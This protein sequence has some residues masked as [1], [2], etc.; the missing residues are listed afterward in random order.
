MMRDM[1]VEDQ[2]RDNGQRKVLMDEWPGKR[3]SSASKF[4][5]LRIKF[6]SGTVHSGLVARAW[7]RYSKE[8]P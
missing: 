6:G 1:G 2:S 3:R 4:G 7:R 5:Q 8:N